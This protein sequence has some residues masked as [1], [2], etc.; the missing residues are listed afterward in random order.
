MAF[1]LAQSI[2]ARLTPDLINKFAG[3][4]GESPSKARAAMSAGG[5]A[6]TGALVQQGSTR[7]GAASLIS[8]LRADSP[9]ASSLFGNQTTHLEG[10]VARASGV[11]PSSSSRVIALLAPIASSVLGR[12]VMS[13]QLDAGGLSSMM[14][15]EK[16]ALL[17]RTDLPGGVSN[18][19]VAE[20]RPDIREVEVAPGR[21]ARDVSVTEAPYAPRPAPTAAVHRK[22]SPWPLI[23]GALALGGLLLAGI[24]ALRGSRTASVPEVPHAAPVV[25]APDINRMQPQIEPPATPV[26]EPTSETTTTGAEIAK[27]ET[28]A[29]PQGEGIAAHFADTAPTGERFTLP[30]VNFEFGTTKL[31]GDGQAEIERMATAMKEHPNTRVRLEGHTDSVGNAEVN[32]PLS[33]GR[34]Q[35]IKDM[36]VAQG[37]EPNRIETAGKRELDPV[38]D[39]DTREGRAQNRRVDAVILSR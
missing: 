22:A 25:R 28:Q 11:S 20:A 33:Y 4:T 16:K 17:S 15:A 9:Q 39:N 36:L 26:P 38:S 2:E 6:M 23:I 32:K 12:E 21:A 37:V 5:L 18:L 19:L 13:R 34:A 10:V 29:A 35:A 1:N 27:P 3:A 8:R 24:S 7:E 31:T 30:G 14:L